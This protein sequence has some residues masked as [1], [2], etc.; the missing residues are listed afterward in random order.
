MITAPVQKA[1]TLAGTPNDGS[2]AITVPRV[3]TT[4]ARLKVACANNIFFDISNTNVE[5]NET[6]FVNLSAPSGA[7]ITDGQGLATILN[8]DGPLLRIS[9]VSS[10]EGN[11]GNKNFVFTVTLSPAAT[12]NVTV[13]C[14]TANGTAAAG[15]DYTALNMI[16]NGGNGLEV[17]EPFIILAGKGLKKEDIE[18]RCKI[19]ALFQLKQ[20]EEYFERLDKCGLGERRKMSKLHNAMELA[21]ASLQEAGV[22]VGESQQPSRLATALWLFPSKEISLKTWSCSPS[23]RR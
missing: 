8:D 1:S 20:M 22:L 21:R 19:T 17:T 11:V 7:A 12:S 10:P 4:Q 2:Q 16:F 15:T 9:A 3:A 14:V 6:F 13:R 23:S 5:P 18:Q